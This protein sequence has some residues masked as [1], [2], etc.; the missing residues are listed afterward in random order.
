MPANGAR[1]VPADVATLPA[2]QLF[3]TVSTALQK[4]SQRPLP[5]VEVQFRDLS[6]TVNL[7]K[8]AA[9]P[10]RSRQPLPTVKNLELPKQ[11]VILNGVSGAFR[12]GTITLVLGQ[13][14]SGKSSLMKILSGRFP[15][16]RDV[17]VS[18]SITFN[19]RPRRELLPRLPQFVAYVDQHDR[20][21][22]MLTVQ[23]TLDFAF[24]CN[25]GGKLTKHETE[26]L[27]Q[28]NPEDNTA[29]LELATSVTKA[30]PQITTNLLG[31]TGCK[32]T[33]V[34]DA[35]IRGISGGQRKRVTTGEMMFGKKN[36]LIMDEI[37]TGLDSA[38][39][40]DIVQVTSR[41]REATQAHDRDLTTAAVARGL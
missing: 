38:A 1:V 4:G 36:V 7:S 20:H 30:M 3:E 2:E 10:F 18:G 24:A 13:P 40:F 34:G 37:S 15:V 8:A 19:G 33:L 25:G 32:D 11:K 17:T 27:T 29:A 28:G 12:P 5:H 39:T 23:E 22:P 35:M 14:G 9:K 31:L 21:L 41:A 16:E 26:F 6:I